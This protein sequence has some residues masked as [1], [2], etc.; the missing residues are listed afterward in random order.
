MH[1]PNLPSHVRTGF[2]MFTIIPL[3]F[4][5]FQIPNIHYLGGTHPIKTTK[6]AT[7][8]QQVTMLTLNSALTTHL[9]PIEQ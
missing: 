6:S 2:S 7:T 3:T 1:T 4:D 9:T 8:S 5:A